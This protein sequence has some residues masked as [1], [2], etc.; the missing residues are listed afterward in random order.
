MRRITVAGVRRRLSRYKAALLSQMPGRDRLD[1]EP[2]AASFRAWQ[3]R[4][5]GRRSSGFPDAWRVHPDLPFNEPARVAVVL[6]VF[7]PELLH[8]IVE[9]L[10]SIPV[11]F[12]L[13]VTN[14]TELPIR[15]D[16]T[17]IP[18]LRSMVVLDVENHGRDILPLVSLVN[19]GLLDP[20]EVVFKVHTKRSVW[21][22]QHATLS[23]SGE[24]WRSDLLQALLGSRA[25]VEEILSAFAETP[26]LGVVT[27]NGSILGTDYWGGDEA[28]TRSLLRRIELDLKAKQLQFPAGSMYWIRGFVLQGLRSLNLTP[29]DF[30]P[31]DGQV[32]ATTA[33][34]VERAIGLLSVEA[35]L[36]LRER[37]AL[38]SEDAAAWQRFLL[39]SPRRR[40]V[41]VLPFYLPQFHAFPDNDRWWGRGF[42][43]WTNVTAAH[44]VYEGHYQPKLP[45]D[46][47]FYDLRIDDVRQA[48]MDLASA[49]GVEGFMY[50]YYWFAGK[51]LMSMPIEKLLASDTQK[52]FCIMWANE[53]WTRRWDGRQ[54]DIL[55]GQ[56]YDRVPA[57]T[58]ID[59][60]LEFLKDPRYV[61]IDGRPV[62]AVYRIAQIPHFESVIAHWRARA[63]EAGAGDLLV[64]NVDVAQEFDGLNK[65]PEEAGLD[66]TLGFPPHNLKW[67]WLLH[68]GLHVDERFTGN[69][70][71]YTAMVEDAERRLLSLAD[72]AYPGVMVNFDNTARR[73]WAS[74]LW[75]GSNPYTFRRWLASAASA[76]SA[77]DP[78]RRI[79]FVNAWNE[80]AEGA[81][82]EPNDRFGRTFLCAVRDV[83]YS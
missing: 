13:L 50:Y 78:E 15:I 71:S 79:V 16:D 68:K 11:E 28:I 76:V 38:A 72:D 52:P 32:D 33:H 27:A 70:L 37:K 47:G 54:S 2:F 73:Q 64:L 55:V 12:D 53:N 40:R 10:S 77:R 4:Q 29:E 62:L 67:A 14:A 17:A 48:Q 74:D 41:R 43:E 83:V 82:L 26:N 57:T 58:F 49:F 3:A 66:G 45:A 59:D 69:I 5:V 44:P 6:H 1:D 18:R 60:V 56:E 22:E 34:G 63:R 65:K 75:Y 30:E 8:E 21:R 24:T 20:Y 39:Q 23:G 19:A 25:N 51:R 35:G 42:T 31:E 9:Q 81:V 80:W 36:A 61:R 7:Y 46:L